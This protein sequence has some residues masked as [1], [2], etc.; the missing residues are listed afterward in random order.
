MTQALDPS[1]IEPTPPPRRIKLASVR[2]VRREM[3]AV[4]AD[5]RQGRMDAVIGT[6]LVYMLVSIAKVL[7]A[8]DLEQRIGVLEGRASPLLPPTHTDCAPEDAVIN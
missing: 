2:G 1:A 5:C 4:Y 6:K 7:E 8:S 3:A